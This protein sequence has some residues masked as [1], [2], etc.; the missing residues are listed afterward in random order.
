MLPHRASRTP[1]AHVLL[2]LLLACASPG[3][4]ALTETANRAAPAVAGAG[5]VAA[6]KHKGHWGW[7]GGHWG[8]QGPSRPTPPPT[9]LDDPEGKACL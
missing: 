5:P 3:V 4:L 6:A 8:G 9:N 2:L 1:R 7:W